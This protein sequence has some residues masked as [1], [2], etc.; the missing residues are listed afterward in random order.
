M[1]PCTLYLACTLYFP[2]EIFDS[3]PLEPDSLPLLNSPRPPGYYLPRPPTRLSMTRQAASHGMRQAS[4]A[5]RARPR[6]NRNEPPL[7]AMKR[8]LGPA[9]P[10]GTGGTLGEFIE[11]ILLRLTVTGRCF[12]GPIQAPQGHRAWEV[13]V[14]RRP[15]FRR[16]ECRFPLCGPGASARGQL[17]GGGGS[18]RHD[19]AFWRGRGVIGRGGLL[20]WS[21]CNSRRR[22]TDRPLS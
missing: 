18:R 19:R 14:P 15:L 5:A 3:P 13:P 20:P 8:E 22:S 16:S 21:T 12:L 10:Q 4:A 6:W 7:P 11:E 2:A 17:A 9:T 1:D